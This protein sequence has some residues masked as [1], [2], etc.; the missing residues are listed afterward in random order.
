[1]I[2]LVALCLPS[3]RFE[4]K[5]VVNTTD[6]GQIM[7]DYAHRYSKIQTKDDCVVGAGYT[8]CVDIGFSAPSLFDAM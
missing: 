7:K 2:Q 1:M 3:E 4:E 8:T 6:S 5:W